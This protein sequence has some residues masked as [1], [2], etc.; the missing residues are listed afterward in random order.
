[1]KQNQKVFAANI[2][3]SQTHLSQVENGLKKPS[4]KLLKQIS[5]YVDV[6]LPIM[7]WFGINEE[8]IDKTKLEAY[9]MLKPTVDA[10][11]ETFY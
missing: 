10:L 7:L 5:E 11:M 4:T 8:D 1:M 3:I 2:G 9:R 6:P